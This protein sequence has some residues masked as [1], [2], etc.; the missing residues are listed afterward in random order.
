MAGCAGMERVMSSENTDKAMTIHDVARELGV[1]ASTVSRAISGKGRIGEATRKRILEYIEEHG[2]YPNAAAQSLAQSRTNNIAII[3]PEVKTLVDMPFFHTCMY[4]IEEVAQ[5]NDY[6]IIV[7][8]TNGKDTKPLERLISNRKVDGMILTRTYEKDFF[9]GYLKEKQIPFVTVGKTA[10]EGIIQVDHDNTGACRELVTVLFSKG[11]RRIA[12]LGGNMGQMVNRSRFEGY[13]EAF[14]KSKRR[15]EEAI[16]Y[17]ELTSKVLVEKAVEELLEE[18]VDCMLCQDDF[19][20]D[21]VVRKLARENVGIPRQMKVASC[22]YSRVL[23]NY[24]VTI[25]SLKF[26]TTELGRRACQLLLDSINNKV[27][28]DMT[29]LDYEIIL[30]ESTK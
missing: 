17:T 2:F 16:V 22:H 7:V 25:T 1:S 24:P 19:I 23:E 27:V 9:A 29:L 18:K 20:C 3:L 10:D 6:D 14:K 12:Y 4:G 8:I 5:A 28:P 13:Q 26:N 21:E 30:K 11:I 15:V